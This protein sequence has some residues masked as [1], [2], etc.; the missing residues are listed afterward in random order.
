MA[1]M[2]ENAP[3]ATNA[4]RRPA[5]RV[6]EL[7]GLRGVAILSVMLYHYTPASGPLRVLA[8]ALQTGWIG[9]DLFFVLSG[10]LIAGIL[11][12]SVGRR[13][14]YRNFIVRRS[15]RIFP[16]YYACLILYAFVTYYPY[17]VDWKVF[18]HSARWYFGYLG[19]FQVFAENRWPGLSIATPL[20]SLQIEEQFYLFFPLLVWALKRRTL[21]IALASAVALAPVLR[22]VMALAVPANVAGT[23]VLAPCRMDAL[24]LGGLIAIATREWPEALKSRW[25]ARVAISAAAGFLAICLFE[26]TTPW[27]PAMRTVGFT[28]LD[29]AFAG[30]VAM[31]VGPKPR[32]L[33]AVFRTRVLVWVGTVSYGLYLLH[34]P[35]PTIAHRLLDPLV[36]IPLRGSADLFVSFAAAFLAAWISWTVFESP[37]LKLKNRFTSDRG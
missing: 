11:L 18:A 32:R 4:A 25:I 17:P 5:A 3:P 31:L 14:Y 28:A 29:L 2:E 13:H 20:W 26:S 7:D 36:K 23:Y 37:I 34:I 9:V 10:Y 19:N 12:D 15:L 22:A 21:A 33:T 6:P 16:L 8:P 27:T 30:V 1:A 35:S 24:A